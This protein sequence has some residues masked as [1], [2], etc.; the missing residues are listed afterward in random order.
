MSKFLRCILPIALVVVSVL[1][2]IFA[3][4]ASAI[5]PSGVALSL[6][7]L[8]VVTAV[9]T[10]PNRLLAS[11]RLRS[12]LEAISTLAKSA[13]HQHRTIFDVHAVW[14][15]FLLNTM[16]R[17]TGRPVMHHGFSAEK[18]SIGALRW[19]LKIPQLVGHIFN[20]LRSTVV[21][22]FRVTV[23]FGPSFAPS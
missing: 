14:P 1:A 18:R 5:A 3:P 20:T 23:G 13:K 8:A 15:G 6:V 7:A 11:L 17:F 21:A 16:H 9:P 4:L 10:P 22:R 19:P 2:I 12:I